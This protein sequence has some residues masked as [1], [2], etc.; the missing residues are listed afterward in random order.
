MDIHIYIAFMA[1]ICFILWEGRNISFS[2]SNK[3]KINYQKL[4]NKYN[5]SFNE[6]FDLYGCKNEEFDCK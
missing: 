2:K 3:N 5:R 6:E 4:I 1:L